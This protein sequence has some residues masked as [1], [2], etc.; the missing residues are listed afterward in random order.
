MLPVATTLIS[1]S[2]GHFLL[3]N[4]RSTRLIV[5][6]FLPVPSQSQKSNGVEPKQQVEPMETDGVK[7]EAVG[8]DS[9]SGGDY[10]V[11]S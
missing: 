4:D 10:T 1:C 6:I 11:D 8:L 2:D 7:K 5:F 3:C 9:E